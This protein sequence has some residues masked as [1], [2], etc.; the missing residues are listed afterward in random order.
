MHMTKLT[1]PPLRTAIAV[2]TVFLAAGTVQAAD[3]PATN[4]P[5][6]KK[7]WESV[8]S[9]GITLTSGNSKNFLAS[10]GLNANRK[11][12]HDEILLGAS[13]GYGQTTFGTRAPND[14]RTDTTQQY[15]KGFSQYNHL[16]N[17]RIYGG[18]RLEGL[19]DKIADVDYRFTISPLA[20][21]YIVKEPATSFAVEAGPSAVVE[22]VGGEEHTYWGGRI[23][24]RFEHKFK[25]AAKVWESA[26]WITQL[27]DVENWIANAEAGVS[28]PIAK[29][30]DV[31]IVVQDSYDNRPAKDRLKNDF[32]LIAGL[33]FR[34]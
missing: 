7:K 8:A 25:S 9:A 28:A 15:V 24:E 27:D 34:F 23:A 18:I 33:G 5:P 21:Y 30:L 13:A 4:A 3:A 22:K 11:W 20:G 12:S 26:E 17:E 31:R 19:Y 32:K 6:A 14:N 2:L 10:I 1:I 29:S 16:F